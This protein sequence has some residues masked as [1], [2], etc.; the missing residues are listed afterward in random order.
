MLKYPRF[1][2][3]LA[4]LVLTAG[5][6]MSGPAWATGGGGNGGGGNG[7]GLFERDNVRKKPRTR[8]TPRRTR[9][10]R[11]RKNRSRRLKQRRT[12]RKAPVVVVQPAA[13]VTEAAQRAN[14]ST[15]RCRRF[16][17]QFTSRRICMTRMIKQFGK[18]LEANAEKVPKKTPAKAETVIKVVESMAR[19]KPKEETLS[20]LEQARSAFAV[21]IE[22]AKEEDPDGENG[23]SEAMQK[24]EMV[25]ENA[26]EALSEA[27]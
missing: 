7:G 23:Y 1:W 13:N 15:E 16:N 19:D 24:I 17:K 9:K 11:S 6:V 22:L 21:S 4:G 26:Y 3:F 12:R 10:L 5:L 27:G 8:R 18:D 25:L 14:E 20:A 2:L